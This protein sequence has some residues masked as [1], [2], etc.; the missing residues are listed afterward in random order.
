MFQIRRSSI[1]FD[2]LYNT[3][4]IVGREHNIKDAKIVASQS[5][6][7]LAQITSQ[8]IQAQRIFLSTLE[9]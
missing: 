8:N 9:N 6:L 2:V 4:T 5:S 7:E 3:F 1:G